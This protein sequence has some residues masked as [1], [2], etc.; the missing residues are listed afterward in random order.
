MSELFT[1][2]LE[3]LNRVNHRISVYKKDLEQLDYGEDSEE[4]QKQREFL[5]CEL[6]NAENDARMINRAIA[7]FSEDGSLEALCDAIV[8]LQAE[9][10]FE[11]QSHVF[12]S[13][14]VAPLK[15]LAAAHEL[16]DYLR[17]RIVV[18]SEEDE[19]VDPFYSQSNIRHLEDIVRDIESGN[20]HFAEHD[21]IE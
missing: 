20:A 12:L 19:P 11:V 9:L 17:N 4:E 3:E 1:M 7:P 16:E 2:L 10:R 18:E 8:D 21:L 13:D 14:A 6:E 15:A 5:Q